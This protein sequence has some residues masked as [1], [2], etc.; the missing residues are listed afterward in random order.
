[1]RNKEIR[2]RTSGRIL[3]LFRGYKAGRESS[4]VAALKARRHS[5]VG[6]TPHEPRPSP[7]S[8]QHNL[9]TLSRVTSISECAHTAER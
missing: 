8:L 9:R 7:E 5:N 6:E 1:M 2:I 4:V 3:I